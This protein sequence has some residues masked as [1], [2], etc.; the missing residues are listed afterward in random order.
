M[1]DHFYGWYFRCQGEEGSIAVIPA[2]HISAKKRSCSIQVITESGSWNRVF[3]VQQ[4]RINRDKGIMQIG[5]NLFSRKGIRLN[6]ETEE[7]KISGILRFGQFAE[8]KYDIMG[9]F[10]YI[11]GMECRHAVYSM[12][13]SV[14]GELRVNGELLRFQNGKAIWKETA[15]APFRNSMPGHS[16]FSVTAL[17]CLR[18]L[19]YRWDR[20][21]SQELSASCIRR[22]GNTGLQLISA[23]PYRK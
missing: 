10:R 16:T 5:E 8:P 4:F 15:E 11:P 1:S 23:R 2:V 20:C 7:L 19:R 9:P 6:L 18:R 12:R 3:P 17:L 21:V 22:G 14:T 13:H